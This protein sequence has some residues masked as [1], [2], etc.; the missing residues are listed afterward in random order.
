MRAALDASDWALLVR[1]CRQALRK[2]PRHHQAHRYLGVALH[3]LRRSEE[4]LAAFA[5]AAVWWPDDAELLLNHSQTL[6]ELARD[7]QALPLM[8]RVCALRPDHYLVWL[9][10]SQCCY[11]LQRHEQGYAAAL[12]T[13]TL[14]QNN[15]QKAAALM[16]KAIHRRELGQVKEAVQDCETAIRLDPSELTVHTNRL[17]FM[18][19]DPD[20]GAMDIRRAAGEYGSVV[21]AGFHA[22]WP[23]INPADHQPWKRLKVGFLSPDFRNH[24]VMYF[25]EGLLA[26]LDRRQFEVVGLHLHP[27]GDLVTD[28]VKRHVDR[29]IELAGLSH[30]AQVAQL[31]AERFDIL[32]DLAGH[33]GNNGLLLMARKLAPLQV[34]WLGYPATT[35]LTAMDYKFT[36][37]VTDPEGAE[38]EYSE[39]LYRMPTLFVAY[40]P[41]V[42]NPLWRYQPAYVVKPAPALA[43][44]YVTFGSCNNL[45][46]LTDEVL[47]LWGQVLAAVPG[48]RLLIEGKN[49]G[50]PDFAQGYRT[51]CEALGIPPERLELVGLDNRNQYLTYHRIDIALDPFPLTGGTTTFDLLWMGV[52]LVS[53]VGESFKSRMGTGILTYLGCADWLADSPERYVAIAAALASDVAALNQIRLSLRDAVEQSPLMDEMAFSQHFGDGLRNIWLEWM[54]TGLYPN[55][56]DGQNT[57]VVDVLQQRPPGWDVPEEPGVGLEPGHRVTLSEACRLLDQAIQ[58]ARVAQPVASATGLIDNKRWAEVTD[59]AEKLLCALPNNP[60]A[61]SCLAEV[62][63]A[64]GHLD[65]AMTYLRQAQTALARSAR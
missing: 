65:F 10:Y 38:P 43:N 16:Q 13:E 15:E 31:W 44:G 8:E 35:G 3:K 51:R 5:K 59:L 19:A 64:H 34:S 62:E 52:P 11:R 40:R 46:K 29:F 21:E 53:M 56:P 24:S 50:Q 61:L 55:D 6:M 58:K 49:L 7:L 63:E 26:Q 36:D 12:K 23:L 4:A 25:V 32:V 54:A 41:M 57:W 37:E 39:K 18:L 14:A 33:T 2:Q 30:S 60:V 1:L 48:S 17:L 45:G 22:H 20:V 28:R 27:S 42:R 9:K 47:K